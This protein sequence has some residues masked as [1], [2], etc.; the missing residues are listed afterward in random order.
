MYLLDTN[1]I[2]ELRKEKPHGA[3]LA[4]AKSIDPYAMLLPAIVIGE[5]Q[6]GAERTRKQDIAKAREIEHY[7]EK[8]LRA[9]QVLPLDAAVCRE[10]ARLIQG[11]SKD[12]TEDA[13]IA[14][15]ARVHSLVVVTRNTKDFENFDVEILNPFLYMQGKKN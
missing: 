1:I 15:T 10:W 2:S 9:F 12:L 13:M 11:K 5:M 6:F 7:I 4:W 8:L 14:A 3:V